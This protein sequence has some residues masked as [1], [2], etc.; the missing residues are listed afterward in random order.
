MTPSNPEITLATLHFIAAVQIL[1]CSI[2]N[3]VTFI[4]RTLTL[5]FGGDGALA[6]IGPIESIC[7][8]V[9]SL[10]ATR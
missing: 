1:L 3:V 9:G 5:S 6:P 2:T 4:N 7:S 8:H 10:D